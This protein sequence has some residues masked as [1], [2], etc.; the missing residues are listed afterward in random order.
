M[1]MRKL[2]IP[3][4][5]V[6]Y[7]IALVSTISAQPAFS[8]PS[9]S[10]L[11]PEIPPPST[12]VAPDAINLGRRIAI[13]LLKT[14]H[15][16]SKVTYDWNRV[17]FCLNSRCVK[18]DGTMATKTGDD[19]LDMGFRPSTRYARRRRLRGDYGS[20]ERLVEKILVLRWRVAKENGG[21][22]GGREAH[23][24]G[25]EGGELVATEP[26]PAVENNIVAARQQCR[27]FTDEAWTRPRGV[28]WTFTW[29]KSRG[30]K[31]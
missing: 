10:S 11:P 3:R 4:V 21:G 22:L 6:I 18:A 20:G 12:S 25:G 13:L 15:Y 23:G 26:D 28:W 17:L 7:I 31:S 16:H 2:V 5:P 30:T 1:M 27:S 24:G 29:S 14:S 8:S 19:R 9:F